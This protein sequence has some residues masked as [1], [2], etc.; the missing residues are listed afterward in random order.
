M[1]FSMLAIHVSCAQAAVWDSKC[2]VINAFRA[3]R[4]R[5]GLE[6]RVINP[7]HHVQAC[8]CVVGCK[9]LDIQGRGSGL[10][11]VLGDAMTK[12]EVE[13]FAVSTMHLRAPQHPCWV[14]VV[15]RTRV[16]CCREYSKRVCKE[17]CLAL[18][19]TSLWV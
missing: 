3:F 18:A 2:G 14:S 16:R 10:H 13:H 9:E 12:A 7:C 6:V 15:A 5:G 8:A 1:V 17:R 11:P 4:A 19:G